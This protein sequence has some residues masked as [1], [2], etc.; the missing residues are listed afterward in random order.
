MRSILSI[1]FI[2]FLVQ[3]IHAQELGFKSFNL[4]A[5]NHPVKI[6]TVYKT[7]QGYI[8]AGTTDGLYAFDGSNCIFCSRSGKIYFF[9]VDAIE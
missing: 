8:L 7:D 2:C 6:N 1:L 4:T 9:K 3:H 5:N